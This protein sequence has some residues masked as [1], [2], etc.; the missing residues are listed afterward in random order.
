MRL[1]TRLALVSCVALMSL[2]VGCMRGMTYK[3]AMP[4]SMTL[5]TVK[6]DPT[7]AAA[8]VPANPRSIAQR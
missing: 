6:E 1:P 4:E 7:L 8:R 2:N 5:G 3:I